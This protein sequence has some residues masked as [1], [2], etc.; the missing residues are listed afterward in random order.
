MNNLVERYLLQKEIFDSFLIQ[1]HK[2]FEMAGL[3]AE[4]VLVLPPNYTQLKEELR[5]NLSKAFK[6]SSESLA[7]LLYRVDVS[8]NPLKE[9]ADTT[10]DFY[11]ALAETII[12]RVLQ[13]V[14]LKRQF[15]T[16]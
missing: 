10:N 12:K 6:N 11:D 15:S 14:I 2:D 3:Q 4:F 8:E 1:L 5:L 16:K 7:N 13:K 9:N